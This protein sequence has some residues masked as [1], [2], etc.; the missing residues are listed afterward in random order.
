LTN[1]QDLPEGTT[2]EGEVTPEDQAAEVAAVLDLAQQNVENLKLTDSQ[3]AQVLS[4]SPSATSLQTSSSIDGNLGSTMYGSSLILSRIFFFP[5]Y[6]Y[7]NPNCLIVLI[8][9][10]L[11]P[12]V[13]LILIHLQRFGAFP[14][15]LLLQCCFSASVLL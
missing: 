14:H 15:F 7:W 3:A 12:F 5:Y 2:E 1:P 9:F 10:F 13:G 11:L 8:L 4:S 6:L